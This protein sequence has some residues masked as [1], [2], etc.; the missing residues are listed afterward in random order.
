M[1]FVNMHIFSLTFYFLIRVFLLLTFTTRGGGGGGGVDL[2]SAY[3]LFFSFL[4][5]ILD[6]Y[7][8]MNGCHFIFEYIQMNGIILRLSHSSK[9]KCK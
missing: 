1:A 4:L 8:K 9:R 3:C 6:K 5:I 2:I 7:A